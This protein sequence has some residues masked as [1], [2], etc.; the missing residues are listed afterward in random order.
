MIAEAIAVG[1]TVPRG[2]REMAATV[3]GEWDVPTR[4]V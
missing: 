4:V 2:L 3:D 1:E